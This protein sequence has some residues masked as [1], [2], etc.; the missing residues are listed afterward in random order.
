MSLPW[1]DQKERTKNPRWKKE[2]QDKFPT[3]TLL[4][5]AEIWDGK[6]NIFKGD[7]LFSKGIIVKVGENIDISNYNDDDN[8]NVKVIDVK[9]K[10]VTPGLVDA[11]SHMGAGSWPSLDATDDV[12][13]MTNPTF[14]QVRVLDGFDPSDP[15]INIIMV[16][17]L[18]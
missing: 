9:G 17:T 12:N 6:G 10:I 18:K 7:V 8:D 4:K 1:K 5:N 14:P 11:H 13:E 3:S 2:Y 15:A 16:N